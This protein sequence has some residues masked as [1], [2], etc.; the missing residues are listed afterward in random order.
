M[1][2]PTF[3]IIGYNSDPYSLN[4]GELF[5]ALIT[6]TDEADKQR[7]IRNY[8]RQIARNRTRKRPL[9]QTITEVVA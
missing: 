9:K 5:D 4:A 1:D 6:C 8:R 2:K 7:R 3:H